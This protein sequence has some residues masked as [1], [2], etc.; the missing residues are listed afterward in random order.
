MVA[1]RGEIAV[2]ILRALREM[3]ISS[4]AVYSEADREALHVRMADEAYCIGP[5]ASE[6]SYL[7]MGKLIAL[8]RERGVDAVHP[9]YGFLAENYRFAQKCQEEGIVFIGPSSEAI[10]IMGSKTESRKA[11][12]EAGVPVVPGTTQPIE[13][14]ETIYQVA[15]E[16]GYP[17]ILKAS[18]GGGGKGMRVISSAEEV[19]TAF[20]VTRSEAQS[21]FGDP[22]IYI[23]KYV[24]TPR[25]IE[26][27]ILGDQQGNLIHLGERECSIQR[28]HQKVIEESPSVVMTEALRQAMGQTALL[29]ARTVRYFSAGTVEFL[30]DRKKNFYFLEMNTRLQVEHPVTEMVTGVDVVKEMIRIAAGKQLRYRQEDIRFRGAAIECRIYAEDPANNFFPCPGKIH[31]LSSPG[32]P[33]IREENGVFPGFEIPI[34]YDPLISKLIAWGTDREEAIQRMRRALEEYTILGVKTTIP[35]LLEVMKDESFMRG[36]IDT[37]YIDRK[38]SQGLSFPEKDPHE[39]I[40]AIA[41]ALDTFFLSKESR[42]DP[43]SSPNGMTFYS[44]WKMAGRRNLLE[45]RW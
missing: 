40:A 26:I 25:H 7:A 42:S 24:D 44:P 29:A 3:G 17:I 22:S 32:G 13:K 5:P 2:R 14:E 16:I 1:N 43:G 20:R 34:F 12:Q 30:V 31:V 9:G 35:F 6:E 33:G 28:R 21:A 10:R 15:E 11:M 38:L 23:E 8:A 19:R 39:K 41:A 27:Q 36:E 18:A 37:G 4:V 45:S